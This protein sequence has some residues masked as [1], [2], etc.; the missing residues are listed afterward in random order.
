MILGSAPP[1][2]CGVG[3]NT[4]E[5][6]KY[7]VSRGNTVEII[8]SSESD[9]NSCLPG[10]NIHRTMRGWS[11]LHGG[12]LIIK[13]IEIEPDV[14]HLQYPSKGYGKG[15]A[16][17]L[18]GMQLKARRI[19]AP[20]IVTLHEFSHAHTMR[21]AAIVPLLSEASAMIIPSVQERDS[22]LRRFGTLKK[23]PSYVIPIG[24][25]LPV[26]FVELRESLKARRDELLKK[27]D[28]KSDSII[29]NYGFI[30]PHKGIEL[31]IKAVSALRSDGFPCE[32]WHI[33]NFNSTKNRYHRFLEY[34]SREGNLRGAV[35]FLG[36]LP[37]EQASEI[38]TIARVGVFPFT[39]GYSDRRSSMI[40]FAHF[41]APLITTKSEIPEV[42]D[43][44]SPYV[45]LID[46]NNTKQL[47][48][49]LIEII[50]NDA[51]YENEKER[52]KGFRDLYDWKLIAEKTE[53]VYREYLK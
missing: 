29:V 1:M 3:D 12:T 25:V 41:D 14:I 18:I 17:S 33:G 48:D 19:K 31:I 39:D 50:A 49:S 36:F 45:T 51:V 22:L 5:L 52:A 10:I 23:I 37:L 2:P 42:D 32:F 35:R 34:L 43:K 13:I 15:F 21:K 47:K 4:I 27:W 38:F 40:S 16:P 6:A 44:I 46:R 24:A 26:G 30:Q 9:E 8:T 11:L 20:L 7:L 28:A 53:A